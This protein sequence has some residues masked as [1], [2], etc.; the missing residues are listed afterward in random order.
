MI[1]PETSRCLE[2][3]EKFKVLINMVIVLRVEGRLWQKILKG[4]VKAV[5]PGRRIRELNSPDNADV[6]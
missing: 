3:W 2:H 5:S 4:I 6:D 1:K